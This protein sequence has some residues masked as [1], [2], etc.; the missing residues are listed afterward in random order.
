[1][2]E[3]TRVCAVVVTFNR[4]QLLKGVLEALSRQ[5]RPIDE[6]L[7]V[8]NASTDGTDELLRSDFPALRTLRLPENI[9]G[10]GGFAAGMKWAYEAGFDW[11][12][13]MDDDIESLP[14][15]LEVL[16]SHRQLSDFLHLRKSGVDEVL[17][18]EGIWDL[19]RLEL[20]MYPREFSFENGKPWIT[21]NYGNF[22]GALIH[23]RIVDRIGLPDVRYFMWSDDSMYGFV[24]SFHTNVL[25]INHIGFRRLLP[26]RKKLERMGVYLLFRNRFLNREHLTKHGIQMSKA[27]FWFDLMREMIWCLRRPEGRQWTL[28]QAMVDGVRDGRLGRF[29]RP[30]WL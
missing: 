25:Y 18:W 12:W 4:K 1:M 10:A 26:Y 22:E 5:T 15:A 11:F 8:D 19:H 14:E 9:G 28:V 27:S 2:S 30:S 21:V 24:A 7:V 29:G 13:V 3:A 23:R 16:L 6:I 20:R 17:S